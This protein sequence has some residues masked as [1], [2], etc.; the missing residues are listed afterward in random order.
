MFMSRDE[1]LGF[2]YRTGKNLEYI[3]EACGQREDVHVAT[4]LVTSS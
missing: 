1:A 3:K 2:A 4:Q